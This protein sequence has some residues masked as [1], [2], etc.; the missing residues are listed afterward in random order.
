[1][2][3]CETADLTRRLSAKSNFSH[4]WRKRPKNPIS[5]REYRVVAVILTPH[6]RG[7]LEALLI[8]FVNIWGGEIKPKGACLRKYL[9]KQDVPIFFSH[10]SS[11]C[12]INAFNCPLKRRWSSCACLGFLNMMESTCGCFSLLM[13][14]FIRKWVDKKFTDIVAPRKWPRVKSKVKKSRAQYEIAFR[15]LS[16]VLHWFEYSTPDSS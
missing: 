5:S 7:M 14:K 2:I 16:K 10:S 1:M 13:A 4:T 12:W 11:S 6:S 3:D 9:Q 15:C 8:I